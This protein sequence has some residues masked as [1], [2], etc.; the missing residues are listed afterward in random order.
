MPDSP[1][2]VANVERTLQRLLKLVIADAAAC[3][4]VAEHP[5][6]AAE[7]LDRLSSHRDERVRRAV[8]TN[9]NAP[10][11]AQLRLLED[12][13]PLVV[14]ELLRS[15][16]TAEQIRHQALA[17]LNDSADLFAAADGNLS[18]LLLASLTR[19]RDVCTATQQ[20]F[21]DVFA[22]GA[23]PLRTADGIDSSALST[24]VDE[25]NAIAGRPTAS[26][27][28]LRQIYERNV[29]S[30]V[31]S[32]GSHLLRRDPVEG[33]EYTSLA[34]QVACSLAYN[35]ST[36][37]DVLADLVGT[38]DDE[39]ASI[40]AQHPSYSMLL[41]GIISGDTTDTVAAGAA[42]NPA[43]DAEVHR[44]VAFVHPA[45]ARRGSALRLAA[46]VPPMYDPRT[47][48]YRPPQELPRD[49]P[50]PGLV[51]VHTP[52]SDVVAEIC[53][54]A[55]AGDDLG[56]LSYVAA[57]PSATAEVLTRCWDTALPDAKMAA[58]RSP[59]PGRHA[60]V[61]DMHLTVARNVLM[62][63]ACPPGLLDAALETHSPEL[64]E[65]VAGSPNATN[66]QV[67]DCFDTPLP[68]GVFAAFAANRWL[69]DD[70]FLLPAELRVAP[71]FTDTSP[72]ATVSL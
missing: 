60:P 64:R 9:P 14:F 55:I 26:P 69:Y 58:L 5:Y 17:S 35:M 28:L 13:D 20:D 68:A 54:H 25:D 49:A 7:T 3:A 16:G 45:S 21:G 19:G 72:R 29:G 46:K 15:E 67:K 41:R 62:H 42:R 71:T 6:A 39:L 32:G 36:P 57:A 56:V 48:M 52:H 66:E 40:V 1:Q 27:A 23:Y 43:A 4:T 38:G 11:R 8:A 12:D 47:G 24:D 63:P 18:P 53:E 50:L 31:K 22:R 65:G 44:H 30:Y 10:Y 33:H 2:R 37:E 34:W 61:S 51:A 70:A 59:A